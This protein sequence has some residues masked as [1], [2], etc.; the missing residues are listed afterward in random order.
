MP[1]VKKRSLSYGRPP[2]IQKPTASL[3]SKATRT[4]IRSHHQ[5]Q[6]ELAK[7][8]S[9]GDTTKAAALESQIE[10]QGGLQSY[11]QASITG[12]SSER[13]GDSSKLLMKW[14]QLDGKTK[15]KVLEVGALSPTNACSRSPALEVTRIDLHSQHPSIE[16]QDFMK[17]PLPETADEKFD[18][19]S[20]SLVLNYVPDAIERGEMLRR[21]CQFLR[22]PEKASNG[23][24]TPPSLFLVLPAPCVTNSRYLDEDRLTNIMQS[25]GYNLT[26]R[27]LSPKLV[28]YLWLYEPK[29]LR[30][31]RQTTFDKRE[32]RPGKTRNNFCVI[33]R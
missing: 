9:Q 31:D 27:K 32:V 20:L 18:I 25:L 21:T 8:I 4:L 12:Q 11:Q 33:L 10:K 17:R 16:T 23:Q 6:K 24:E 15:Y 2:T 19:L 3:S 1:K 5:L 14:L 30:L 28:Y 29:A 7:A 22:V 26:Q 13:G